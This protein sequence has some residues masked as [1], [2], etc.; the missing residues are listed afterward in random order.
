MY[1]AIVQRG[2]NAADPES[3]LDLVLKPI[4]TP[5]PG[6]VVVHITLRPINPTDLVSIRT[7][8]VAKFYEYPVTVG[9]EGFGIVETVSHLLLTC[10]THLPLFIF[11][12]PFLKNFSLHFSV[13]TG[14]L[15]PP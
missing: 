1:R 14:Y 6:H 2:F 7:G 4:P 11:A 9:S 8:R 10:S 5:E 15:G 13:K 12:F 3:A